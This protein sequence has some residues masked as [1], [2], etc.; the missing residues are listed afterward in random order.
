MATGSLVGE[1]MLGQAGRSGA[2]VEIY[3]DPRGRVPMLAKNF[4]NSLQVIAKVVRACLTHLPVDTGDG[5][6]R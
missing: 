1:A 3:R 2:V 5:P 6:S 4:G